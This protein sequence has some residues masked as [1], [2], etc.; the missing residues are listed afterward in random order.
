MFDGDAGVAGVT[1]LFFIFFKNK[2]KDRE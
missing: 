2:N 1:L